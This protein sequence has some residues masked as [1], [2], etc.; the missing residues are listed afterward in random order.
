MSRTPVPAIFSPPL[1]LAVV[2]I[3][4]R[5]LAL[6]IGLACLTVMVT[7]A[8][9]NPSPTGIGT[10]TELGLDQC[11][12]ALRTGLPCPSCGMT[13]SFAWLA[14]GNLLAAFYV[15][16]MGALLGL[17][18]IL[19]TWT[20][21]YV[22]VTGR[23]VYRLIASPQPVLCPRAIGLGD[24]RLGVEDFHPPAWDRWLGR[25]TPSRANQEEFQICIASIPRRRAT[26]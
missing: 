13:T 3:P 22:A 12:F 7:A 20:G 18:T 15:Q 26:A 25:I 2:G 23:A 21:F 6:M 8:R 4:G 5:L 1:S 24:L 10:H 9:L 14:R 19:A 17:L 11:Q 16:P